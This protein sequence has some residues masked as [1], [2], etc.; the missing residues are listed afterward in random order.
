MAADALLDEKR[1]GDL[2]GQH[3]LVTGE[4]GWEGAWNFQ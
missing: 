1:G 3:F 2:G 4:P